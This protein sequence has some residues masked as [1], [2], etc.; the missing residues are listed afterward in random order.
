MYLTNAQIDRLNEHNQMLRKSG[1]KALSHTEVVTFFGPALVM[2]Y[3]CSPKTPK[4]ASTI[5]AHHD[6]ARSRPLGRRERIKP[7]RKGRLY[8][9]WAHGVRVYGP[10]SVM[11]NHKHAKRA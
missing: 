6:R 1:Q 2:R 5:E 7:S 8:Y 3:T 10:A 9:E 4:D 11:V